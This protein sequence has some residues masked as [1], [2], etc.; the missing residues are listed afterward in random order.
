MMAYALK[1]A[2]SSPLARGLHAQAA[3]SE[4]KDWIIPAR[5]GFTY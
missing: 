4:M 5:A 2:G 3:A 1:S